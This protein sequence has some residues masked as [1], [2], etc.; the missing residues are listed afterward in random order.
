M[1]VWLPDN[2]VQLVVISATDLDRITGS[3][4]QIEHEVLVGGCPGFC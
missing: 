3:E 2:E 4:G 1:G